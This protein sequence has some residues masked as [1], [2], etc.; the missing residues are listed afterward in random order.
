MSRPLYRPLSAL[1]ILASLLAGCA[2]PAPVATVA[3]AQATA[4]PPTAVPP[5]AVPPTAVP[6]R[7]PTDRGA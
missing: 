7:S 2:Q 4:V 1:L 6:P 5:T 3:P